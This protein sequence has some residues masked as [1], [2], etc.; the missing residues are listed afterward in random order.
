MKDKSTKRRKMLKD[1]HFP[2]ADQIHKYQDFN[3]LHKE[4]KL[5]K[6]ISV[7][8][9]FWGAKTFIGIVT[10]VVIIGT[11][12]AALYLRKDNTIY[13]NQTVAAT[14]RTK[15]DTSIVVKITDQSKPVD[16]ASANFNSSTSVEVKAVKKATIKP[17]PNTAKQGTI[18][19]SSAADI[20]NN[21]R[22]AEKPVPEIA[23]ITQ[24]EKQV[25]AI[26]KNSIDDKDSIKAAKKLPQIS[27]NKIDSDKIIY[28]TSTIEV[29]PE[30]PGGQG[31]LLKFL[32]TNLKYPETEKSNGIQGKAYVAFVI[33]K[34]G[35]VTNVSVAKGITDGAKLDQEAV[36]VVKQMPYWKPGKQN[37]KSVSV[38]Y[39]LPIQ[40]KVQ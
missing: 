39:M 27:K 19:K 10:I 30:F 6:K 28:N 40:F 7:N 16:T 5:I 9:T 23:N 21:A 22:L 26:A 2:D 3:R 31:A 12:T 8:T 38:S 1:R 4:Y 32:S 33:D 37:G 20:K 13:T 14:S 34:F 25:E 15:E 35:R 36:R 17:L 29:Q 11:V 18:I 24:K